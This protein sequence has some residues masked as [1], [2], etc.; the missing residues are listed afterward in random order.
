MFWMF[1][2]KTLYLKMRK[3]DHKTRKIVI[4]YDASYGNLLELSNIISIHQRNLRLLLTKVYKST[5]DA[6]PNLCGP[7][8]RTKKCSILLQEFQCLLFHPQGQ[9]TL[10]R[11]VYI[12]L[13][14]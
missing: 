1:C 4:Q 11:I 13:A 14:P 10:V 5:T 12:S 3:I 7:F 6:N 9:L 2:K 8:L